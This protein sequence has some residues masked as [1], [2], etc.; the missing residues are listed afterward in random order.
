[1]LDM[2][3]NGSER[4]LDF[5][6]RIRDL[7]LLLLLEAYTISSHPRRLISLSFINKLLARD[8]Y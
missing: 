3:K 1:M 2:F 6:E 7:I 4:D 8:I 5:Q